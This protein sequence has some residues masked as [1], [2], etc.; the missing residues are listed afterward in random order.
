MIGLTQAL[1]YTIQCGPETLRQQRPALTT[2]RKDRAM[3]KE[4]HIDIHTLRQLVEYDPQTG[5]FVWL[6]RPREMFASLRAYRIFITK[7]EGK[8]A[9][10]SVNE[11][12][13]LRGYVFGGVILAHRAAWALHFN[14]WPEGDIDHINGNPADNRI[15]NL[16][17]VDNQTNMRNKSRS[18]A[19]KSGVTGVFENKARGNWQAYI[20]SNGKLVRLGTFASYGDAVAARKAAEFE[21]GYHPNHDRTPER[22][23]AA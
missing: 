7:H 19:N 13:Y 21:L 6:P 16:R 18:R 11:D 1:A 8:R 9:L 17:D 2:T 12:G 22:E 5:E 23:M 20:G 3:A 15:S 14:R 4:P 10:V